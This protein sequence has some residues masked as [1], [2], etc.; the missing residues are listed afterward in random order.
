MLHWVRR[1]SSSIAMSGSGLINRLASEVATGCKVADVSLQDEIHM[2][3][4]KITL[5]PLCTE[6]PEVEITDEGVSI[7]EGASAVALSADRPRKSANLLT[8]RIYW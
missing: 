7:G 8:W 6:C 3:P 4:I 2:E 5:C 1:D